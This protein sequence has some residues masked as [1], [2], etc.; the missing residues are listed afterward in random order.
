MRAKVIKKKGDNTIM[1]LFNQMTGVEDADPVLIEKKYDNFMYYAK[2][3]VNAWSIFCKSSFAE[4]FEKELLGLA[5][6]KNFV[7]ENLEFL[8][9]ELQPNEKSKSKFTGNIFDDLIDMTGKYNGAELNKAYREL[10]NSALIKHVIITLDRIKVLLDEDKKRSGRILS[11]LDLPSNFNNEFITK[12]ESSTEMLSFSKLNFKYL[13]DNYPEQ[14][15]DFNHL[16]LTILS[17]TYKNATEI[18]KI[19][20]TPDIDIDKFVT[21]FGEKL[22]QIKGVIPDCQKAFKTLLKSLKL[23]KNNFQEYY[24][25]FMT[26]D[27]PSIIFESF[28]NDV[29]EKNKNDITVMLQFKKIVAYIKQNMPSNI[30]QNQSVKALWEISDK[31]FK[32]D[33]SEKESAENTEKET[34]N[35]VEDDETDLGSGSGSF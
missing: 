26:T 5:E 13:Y 15:D 31:I 35:T 21:A 22:E 17:I 28:L 12:A 8:K 16:V 19:F 9:K 29:Q 3:I 33:T 24:K 18:Y 1:K 25:K 27:N 32:D 2:K 4:K 34:G 7:A 11:G 10:K 23:L 6:I 14:V 30:R 20:I